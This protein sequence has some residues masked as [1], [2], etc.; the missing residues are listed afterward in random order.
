MSLT[1]AQAFKCHL[2]CTMCSMCSMCAHRHRRG[3]TAD[4]NQ[5]IRAVPVLDCF[6]AVFGCRY[7]NSDQMVESFLFCGGICCV[8]MSSMT[9]HL[10]RLRGKQ[11]TDIAIANEPV[12]DVLS[13]RTHFQ[14]HIQTISRI[15]RKPFVIPLVWL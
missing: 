11:C 15:I 14:S 3:L 13:I 10:F 12:I 4:T 8:D 6:G 7:P 9:V 2:H 1:L 5:L